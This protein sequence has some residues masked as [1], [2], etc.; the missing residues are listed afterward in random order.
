MLLEVKTQE[1]RPQAPIKEG[2]VNNSCPSQTGT[3]LAL[4]VITNLDFGA[5]HRDRLVDSGFSGLA[6]IFTCDETFDAGFDSGIDKLDM[7]WDTVQRYE[8][9]NC[10]LA[11]EC[12][13]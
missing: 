13:N 1:T 2:P 3:F 9:D 7:L 8:I 6:T 10:I 12:G 4:E 5:K 11:F